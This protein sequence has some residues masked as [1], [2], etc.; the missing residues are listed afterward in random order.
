MYFQELQKNWHTFGE[1]DPLWAICTNPKKRNGKWNPDAFFAT[2]SKT[3][4]Q[5]AQWMEN[6]GLPRSRKTALDFGCGVGRLT[7]ALCDHFGQCVGVDIAPSMIAKA[8]KF[9]RHGTRCAYRVNDT[10]DLSSFKDASFDLVYTKHVLQHM[11]PRLAH[12]YI[13]EFFRVLRPG[14]L[15]AFHCPSVK[16]TFAYPE[17]DFHCVVSTSC[18]SL[19]MEASSKKAVSVTVTNTGSHPIGRTKTI[20]API[21]VIH[22]WACR[23]SR[24]IQANHGYMVLPIDILEPGDTLEF[25]YLVPAPAKPGNYWLILEPFTLKNQSLAMNENNYAMLQTLITPASHTD[26]RNGGPVDD[27]RPRMEMN[28]TPTEDVLAIVRAVGGRMVDIDSSQERPGGTVSTT[29][30]ATRD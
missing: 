8:K 13:A 24:A 12:R 1:E 2:G 23:E 10:T 15:A 6:R 25:Q 28:Y 4:D 3:I 17:S 26:I 14:G 7:Q 21:K 9:N 29:Y 11:Q 18:S 20:N 22:H 27:H 19:T 16:P 5:L 30:Y